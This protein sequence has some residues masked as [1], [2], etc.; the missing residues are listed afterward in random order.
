MRRVL[1]VAALARRG[2]IR[3]VGKK[4]LGL[5]QPR[6]QDRSLGEELRRG[7]YHSE[8]RMGSD[9]AGEFRVAATEKGELQLKR[10]SRPCKNPRAFKAEMVN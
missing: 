1:R 2:A 10:H 7:R 6:R 8:R 5:G 9:G 4:G 3:G